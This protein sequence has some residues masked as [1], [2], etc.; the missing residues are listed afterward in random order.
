MLPPS[1]RL[2]PLISSP[3]PPHSLHVAKTLIPRQTHAGARARP[4]A[5]TMS[6]QLDAA[7]SAGFVRLLNA[8][9]EDADC[10]GGHYDPKPGDYA[11]GIVVSGTEA[12]LDVAVGADR[13]ATLLTKELLPLCRAEL[14]TGGAK[15]APPRPG[16]VGV[17]ETSPVDEETQNQK[18]GARTLVPPGTVVFAEVL[19]RTLSG[20]PLLSARRL[21]R[22]LSW[23]RARQ[24]MQLDEPI[25]VKIYEWNTGGLLTRIE[26]LRAFLPK[27]ELMD[28]ISTF[29]DLKN[30][31]MT[32][33]KE[34]ALLKGNVHKIFPYGAQ[35]R[36][37]GT[38]RSGLLHISNIS[39]GRVLSVSDILK[40]D[41]E[42]KVLVI[43]SNVSDKIALSIADLESA[44]GLFLSDKAKVFSEAQEMAK[45][46]REQLPVV[47]RNTKL[48]YDLRGE[49]IPFDNEA[50]LY[51]NW[52][53]FKFLRHA[54]S[55]D[56]N[57]RT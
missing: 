1:C 41:D 36:I 4:V 54:K 11:V 49:T 25:E 45:R 24:I 15:P 8:G 46:Y 40:V 47:S 17:S 37:T 22:R 27:F 7:L 43:K 3:P 39:Q 30:N 18:R 29:T 13:L 12:R 6:A 20:R 57:D 14:P 52:K 56:E 10:G 32:Y 44:P 5:P 51:A 53:W 26:G 48:D 2:L 42:L 31:E 33:L 23:H 28:R 21:F 55:G 16:S 50:T 35:V 19:G 38:N 9:Q 34:G